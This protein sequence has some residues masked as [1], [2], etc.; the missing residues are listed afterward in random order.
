VLFWVVAVEKRR[1]IFVFICYGAVLLPFN[2]FNIKL[3]QYFANKFGNNKK[4][5]YF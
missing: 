3:L 5:A 2:N 1:E 4:G